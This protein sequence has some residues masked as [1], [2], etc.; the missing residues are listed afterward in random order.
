MM[1]VKQ[2]AQH[3]MSIS[4]GTILLLVLA[5]ALYVWFELKPRWEAHIRVEASKETLEKART[6]AEVEQ[7]AIK[8]QWRQ[9]EE[10]WENNER[11]FRAELDRS[12]LR[13]AKLKRER[14]EARELGRRN[15]ALL[16]RLSGYA[17]FERVITRTNELWDKYNLQLPESGPDDDHD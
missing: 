14:D 3:K 1:K 17:L 10:Q 4:L 9:K 2:L 11:A 15:E 5:G 6:Q 16:S 7:A 13:E 12:A 8:E